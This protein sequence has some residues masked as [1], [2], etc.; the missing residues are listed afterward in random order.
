MN[1]LQ[2]H[3]KRVYSVAFT[4]DERGLLSGGL[5]RTLKYWDVSG[6]YRPGAVCPLVGFTY[7]SLRDFNCR[8]RR[9]K[10]HSNRW[11]DLEVRCRDLVEGIRGSRRKHSRRSVDGH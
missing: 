10:R 1:R 5:D 8:S 4:P 7:F 9:G 11:E 6:L 3:T 2:R